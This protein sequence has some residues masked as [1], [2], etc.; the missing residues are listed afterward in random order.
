MTVLWV[1]VGSG[2]GG[3]GRYWIFEFMARHISGPFPWGTLIVNVTGSLLI[4][5]FAT[6]TG[7][8]GRLVLGGAA[9]QFVMLGVLGGFT[10]FSAFSLQTLGLIQEGDW[11]PAVVNIVA[12]VALCLIG[13]WAGHAL[14]VAI[15]R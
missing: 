14:A 6:L 10:T 7:P 15:N 8:E 11:R 9:R 12:S 3:A 4:G 1:A 5:A 2:L 13:V